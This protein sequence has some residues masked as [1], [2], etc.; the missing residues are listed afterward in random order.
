MK[1]WCIDFARDE[2]GRALLRLNVQKI[3]VCYKT[4]KSN[5]VVKNLGKIV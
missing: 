5:Y 4:K 3:N 1:I 2:A